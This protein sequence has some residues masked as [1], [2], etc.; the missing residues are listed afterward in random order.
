LIAGGTW[1]YF[2]FVKGR[3]FRESLIP[4]VDGRFVLIDGLAFL[5]VT[6]QVKNVGSS[7]VTFDREMSAV[8]IFEY[9]PPEADEVVTV[10]DN[11]LTLFW[12]F[13]DEKRHLEPNETMKRQR[14]IVL[15]SVTK[16]AYRLEFVVRS[17]AGY[18]WRT[19]TIVD[20][21]T[22]ANNSAEQFVNT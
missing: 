1:A 3:A 4:L 11:E 16:M 5:I 15:S 10:R 14:L 22:L 21:L 7:H 2:K 8:T 20:T 9:V 18:V 6:T 17:N 12:V 13:E 19:M